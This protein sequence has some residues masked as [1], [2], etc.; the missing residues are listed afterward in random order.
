MK[1]ILAVALALCT[2]SSALFAQDDEI[3]RPAI[4]IS[5]FFNDFV[6]PER[7]KASNVAG[8]LR[9]GKW[10]NVSEMKGGLAVHY[11]K[12]LRKHVDFAGTLA[13]S[14]L[15]YPMPG[16]NFTNDN[17]LLEADASLNLKMLSEKHT[18]QPY[19]TAGVGA[20]WYGKYWGAV[21]PLGVGLKISIFDE[22]HL[23]S[24]FQYRVP[25]TNETTA[26]HFFYSFG[27]AGA[28]TKKKEPVVIPPPPPPRPADTDGDGINDADDKCPTERGTVKYQGCPVPDT[29]KDGVND[30]NDKCPNVSGVARYQGCPIPDTD[31]DGLNDED[32]KCPN[33]AGVARYQGCPVPDGDGDGVNDEEDKCPKTAGPADNFGCPV[34]GIKFH[35]VVFKSGSAVLLQQGKDVLDTVVTYMKKN[36]GV[37]VTID[38]HTDN[39]G[40]DKINN[41]L[42]LKRAEA[43]KA[44]IVSKGVDANRMITSGFGSKQPIADNKTA[45][46]RKKNRRIEI[47]IKD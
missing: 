41:P 10:A 12:G 31:N 17:L 37:I 29:D 44:Y 43:V 22:A 25:V 3:R 27:V 38:G 9:D 42:S 47:K 28:L 7:I 45:A 35:E 5:F 39:T 40:S 19:I 1:K 15:R 16:K 33:A 26:H 36:E 30:D 11:F 18:V 4:G 21:M 8:I 20:S 14:F 2:F 13:G 34:I 32:D 46:G 24:T 6:T 23:F